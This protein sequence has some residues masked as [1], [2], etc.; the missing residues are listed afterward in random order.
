MYASR[1]IHPALSTLPIRRRLAWFAGTWP[2]RIGWGAL[3]V[4]ACLA[5]A[6]GIGRAGAEARA[7]AASGYEVVTVEPGDTL[8]DIAG[9]RYP[10]ADVRAKVYEIEQVNGLSGPVIMAGQR[11][12]VPVR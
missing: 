7:G 6:A 1:P 8:W 3:A 4:V 11:L 2:S 5:L 10:G 9:Q 12:K